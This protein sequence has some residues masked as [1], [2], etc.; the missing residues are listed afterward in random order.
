M[1]TLCLEQDLV[2][3][4]PYSESMIQLWMGQRVQMP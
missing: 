4:K 3:G 1:Q 2:T